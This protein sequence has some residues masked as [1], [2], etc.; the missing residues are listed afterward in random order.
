[1]NTIY[2]YD[3]YTIFIYC[4]NKN[5]NI[6]YLLCAYYMG[7][8]PHICLMCFITYLRI[9]FFCSFTIANSRKSYK[10]LQ[11]NLLIFPAIVRDHD[12]IL[13][14]AVYCQLDNSFTYPYC[15]L[16][17]CLLHL[18]ASSSYSMGNGLIRY[19]SLFY[20][21]SY[22]PTITS[23]TRGDTYEFSNFPHCVLKYQTH[24]FKTFYI[25]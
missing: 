23:K 7:K 3:G 2:L 20:N 9:L 18:H 12:Y 17:C 13:Y 19:R 14:S 21:V 24:L 25:V 6:T 8:V 5:E 4:K 16:C 10:T 1:M 22:K 11:M 15:I